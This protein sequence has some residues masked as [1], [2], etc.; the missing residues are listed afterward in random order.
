MDTLEFE[1]LD[2]PNDNQLEDARKLRIKTFVEEQGFPLGN[3]MTNDDYECWHVLLKDKSQVIGNARVIKK[4]DRSYL[5]RVAIDIDY[6]GNGY[7]KLL[8]QKVLDE[9]KKRGVDTLYLESQ[10]HVVNFYKK[11][12][13]ETEGPVFVVEGADHQKMKKKIQ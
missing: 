8:N 11:L 12:G 5:G 3:E 9:C 1:I 10:I 6:R 13:F 7:G 2:K 4:D